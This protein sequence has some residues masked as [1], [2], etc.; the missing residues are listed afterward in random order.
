MNEPASTTI[1]IVS[2][3]H[4][5]MRSR[6]V[7]T[8]S[9]AVQ[10]QPWSERILDTLLTELEATQV[11]LA[12]HLGDLTC[13]GGSYAMPSDVFTF[14]MRHLY[15]RLHELSAPIV[16]LP[17]NHDVHPGN[18]DLSEFHTLWRYEPGLGKL[19][20]LPEARLI[21]LNTMGHTP[22]QIAAAVDGDPVFGWVNP[23]ELERLDCA[24]ATAE[25]RPVLLFTHQLLHPWAGERPWRDYFGVANAAEV[26]QVIQRRGGV[27]AI[28]QGH[29][30]RLDVQVRTLGDHQAC[31]FAVVPAIIDYP[32]AWVRL[33]LTATQARWALQRLPLEE[34]AALSEHSGDGQSWRQGEPAWWNYQFPLC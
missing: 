10:L 30:H 3:T 6:P 23:A 7:V 12:L 13:G 15:R 17:G 22:A 16:A 21:L 20:D 24:L 11:D 25:G 9:G 18:G 34:L 2:D 14:T 5:W 4:F 1:G 19:I 33:E 32:V 28:F 29:A 27:R 26:L 31:V 8:A